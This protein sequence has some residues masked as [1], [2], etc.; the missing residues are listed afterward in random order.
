MD[1]SSKID[2]LWYRLSRR[3]DDYRLDYSLDSVEF[4]QMRMCHLH[5]G[6]QKISF[7]IYA[8]SPEQ[9]SFQAVFSEFEITEC[10]WKA[11]V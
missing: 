5:Q 8:C 1:V 4:K 2:T 9:S 7:G 6:K 11:H 10:L 3:K